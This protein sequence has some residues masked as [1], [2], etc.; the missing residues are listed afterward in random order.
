MYTSFIKLKAVKYRKLRNVYPHL[1]LHYAYVARQDAFT[2][3][4][5]FLK[6]KRRV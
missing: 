3:A 2:R 5:S 1:P 4:K 6:L